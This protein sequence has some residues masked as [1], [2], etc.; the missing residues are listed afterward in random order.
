MMICHE[1][2]KYGPIASVKIMWPRTQEERERNRNCGFVSFMK[3]PDAEQ[4][5]KNLDGK[6]FHDFV[7]KVG[8]GKAVPLPATPVF[9]K[10][11]DG[12]VWDYT[13][14]MN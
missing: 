5:L 10:I 4:A 3:R 7:M 1:F 13:I 6:T 12:H 8:W 14:G 11:K 9:G 2:G